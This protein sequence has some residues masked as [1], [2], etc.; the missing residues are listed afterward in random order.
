M[1]RPN[2]TIEDITGELHAAFERKIAN[3]LT[4]GGLL[5]EARENLPVRLLASVG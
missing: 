3:I 5:A 4:I 2:R 1:T